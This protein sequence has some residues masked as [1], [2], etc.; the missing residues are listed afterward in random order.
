MDYMSM[1]RAVSQSV[2]I[3]A[4][5]DIV[6]AESLDERLQ[7]VPLIY[8]AIKEEQQLT[9]L[10]FGYDNGDYFI[11]RSL[12]NEY[13]S[14][15]F[16]APDQ[17]VIVVDNIT[18]SENGVRTRS[19]FWY[20]DS[21]VR[22][23]KKDEVADQYD[24]RV[25]PWYTAA[26]ASRS[27]TDTAPYLFHFIGQMGI[28]VAY[29]PLGAHCV[30]A[31][32]ITLQSLSEILSSHMIS[33]RTE[34]VL[35]EERENSF[36]V[37][38]YR[39]AE[40]LTVSHQE[41]IGRSELKD[42]KSEILDIAAAKN[43]IRKSFYSIHHNGEDWLGSTLKLK[44]L[45][46]D[47]FYL[48]MLS[49]EDEILSEARKMQMQ[50]SIFTIIMIVVA[51]PFSLVLARKIAK[52]LQQLAHN[53]ER[54][55]R[56]E[57]SQGVHFEKT[58][59]KE[60]DD[61]GQAMS[62]MEMTIDQFISLINSLASEQDFDSLLMRI[63]EETM[64]IAEADC[65]FTYVVK[66]TTNTLSPGSIHTPDSCIIN[67]GF[68][69][70]CNLN[71]SSALLNLLQETEPV[72]GNIDECIPGNALSEVVH[73]KEPVVVIFPAVNRQGETIGLL[74]LLYDKQKFGSSEK[75][76]GRLAFLKALSG[77]VAVTLE[78]RQMLRMQKDLLE[79]F[80]KVLAEAIDSKS[81]YTGGH[82]KRIPVLTELIAHKACA[83]TE[84]PFADF[85][86]DKNRWEELRIAS[87]LHD[88]GK[89]TSPEFI[90]DKATKLE[91]IYD[92]I[93]EIRMR[94]EVIKRDVHIAMLEQFSTCANE[95]AYRQQLNDL[96]KELDEEFTF[97]AE[98]NI[99][100]EYMMPE[101][102]ERLQKISKRTW[103]RTLSDRLGVS[104]EEKQRKERV[105]E[106]PLPVEERLLADRDDHL[107]LREEKHKIKKNNPYG[108]K[109]DTPEY[110]YNR[111]ELYNLSITKGTLTREDRYQ[112]NDHIVQTIIML[113]KLPFP[114]HLKDIPDIAGG[115]HEKLDGT[116]YPR[117]LTSEQMPLAAKIMVLADIF[118]ALTAADRP[119][120]NAKKL[121]TV[122]EIMAEMVA[123]NHIDRNIF[124][125]F[126][127]SGA[128][129]EYAEQYL[130]KEQ[131]DNVD[132]ASVLKFV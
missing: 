70:E 83:S 130:E 63:S 58:T 29:K 95:T 57:F 38:A 121:S 4:H 99:G 124:H 1:H 35:L 51:G 40:A 100:Q 78:G 77:F 75:Q 88:C 11:V 69:P 9:A 89:V 24:P 23:G 34:I 37:T 16:N 132:V 18:K 119:Y 65:A 115:H 93:H 42:L 117:K 2:R 41:N 17:A 128:Y 46:R 52:P 67:D 104:W 53:S 97:V 10:Q 44:L 113:K 79:S 3:V 107:I 86:L 56:F 90:V 21:M 31:G 27:V 68:L 96:W 15:R 118:E 66:T 13:M 82:C 49:P 85:K 25:R 120:K 6:N 43:E 36:W 14:K 20:T 47:N 50:T 81:T 61:L 30:I 8:S 123:D 112:I 48:V 110:L 87:W 26:L 92:R 45:N 131:V 98:C 39:D 101:N 72:I 55:S 108:F 7:F 125:L 111:G 19:R 73:L 122:I 91:T 33:K 71:E 22:I 102:I 84:E 54:I 60:V 28:T 105:G 109:L 106:K 129:L 127:T 12:D 64:Q 32:D 74:C 126:L 62:K 116:G 114:K 59:I 94:F 76:K 103:M 5:T 80:I